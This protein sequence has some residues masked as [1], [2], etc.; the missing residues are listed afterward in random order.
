MVILV[1]YAIMWPISLCGADDNINNNQSGKCSWYDE[2]ERGG[3]MHA[4][5]VMLCK[6][7]YRV[8]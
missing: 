5:F 3:V 7:A 8:I 6:I 2:A 1:R 4:K